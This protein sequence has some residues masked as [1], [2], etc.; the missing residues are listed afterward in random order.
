MPLDQPDAEN[1]QGKEKPGKEMT[2]LEHLEELRWHIIRSLTAIV[3]LG[4]IL[5]LFQRWL[6]DT[7]IFGPTHKEFLTYRVFCAVVKGLGLSESMCF[8]PPQFEKIAIGFGEPFIMSIMVS[9]VMGFIIAFPYVLWEFWRFIKPGLYPKEKKAARGM[10]LIC[11]A[12]FLTGVLFGYYIIAPFAVNFLAGYSIPGVENTP[13]M[14]SYINYMIMFTAPAG[15]IFEL[16]I[17]VYFLAK[18]GLVSAQD[19]RKY[20]RHS[21]IGIL[22]LAAVLT[23]PDV[24]TQFL[25]AIPLYIL[26][27]ASIVIAL[28]VYKEDEAE[29]AKS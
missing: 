7:V 4:I 17:V 12:L 23:P 8:E 24:V 27:E 20:R 22:I 5:F 16:P 1:N 13:T 14:S 18:V 25:I 9:F 21:I 15:L 2:F 11:S 6:F 19:M 3:S 29:A 26:Y 28:R 10:V